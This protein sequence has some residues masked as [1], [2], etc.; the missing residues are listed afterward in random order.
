MPRRLL[1]VT[2]AAFLVAS[3]S[4]GAGPSRT[5]VAEPT[6]RPSAVEQS[7]LAAFAPGSPAA[8]NVR[9][10]ENVSTPTYSVPGTTTAEVR[11][12]MNANGPLAV[13][14]NRRYDG[15]TNWSLRWSFRFRENRGCTILNATIE[16]SIATTLPELATPEALPAD[17]LERWRSYIAALRGHEQGH[18]ERE[19]GG[20]RELKAAFEQAPVAPTCGE[21]GQALNALGQAQVEKIMAADARYDL[22]T[23][24]GRSQGAT[25]P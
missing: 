3:C 1:A 19:L 4:F 6:P 22:D 11:A 15:V 21:L 18:V 25:F 9:I 12:Y 17:S 7:A 20:A 2:A 13:D 23:G 24:H 14:D 10:I 8:P 5:P 16:I